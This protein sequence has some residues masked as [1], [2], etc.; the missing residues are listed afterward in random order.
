MTRRGAGGSESSA[1]EYDE[2]C[3]EE[4]YADSIFRNFRHFP[5]LKNYGATH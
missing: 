1:C 5:Y 4:E 2:K 3:Q